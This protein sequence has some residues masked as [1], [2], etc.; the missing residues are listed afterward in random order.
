MA[1]CTIADLA[2]LLRSGDLR[3]VRLS[4][5]AHADPDHRQYVLSGHTLRRHAAVYSPD[6]ARACAELIAIAED[7]SP[8]GSRAAPP[9]VL[10]AA[11]LPTDEQLA[12][13]HGL[14]YVLTPAGEQAARAYEDEI[15]G[16]IT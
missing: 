2:A 3:D 16:M 11:E 13:T 7:D 8:M 10:T 6:F 12:I 15:L 1:A 14:A 9:A 5:S 4:C